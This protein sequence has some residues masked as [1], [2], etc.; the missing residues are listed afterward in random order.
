MSNN[1]VL[2]ERRGKVAL[3][4]I[5]RPEALNAVNAQVWAGLGLALEE[6]GEDSNL[7]CAVLTGAGDRAFCA[8]SDLKEKVGA[9]G[10][11]V[12]P[13]GSEKWGYGGIAQHYINKPIIAAVNGFALG[14]GAEIALACDLIVASEKATFGLPEVKKGLLAGGGGLLRLPRQI[15]LKVAMEYILTGDSFSAEEAKHW[16]LVNRVVPHEKLI[17]E[18]FTL[19]VRITENAPLAIRASK[20]IVYRSLDVSLDHPEEAWAINQDYLQQ[21]IGNEDS[22]EGI[23]AFIEKRKPQWQGR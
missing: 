6:F 4:T 5:N 2:F 21:V 3:I 22:M 14:G 9:N 18:A 12:I 13:E 23:K 10:W 16:G 19:A 20:D 8:G 15:P 17:D 7:W 11:N 1:A